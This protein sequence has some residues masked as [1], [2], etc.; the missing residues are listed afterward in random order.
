MDIKSRGTISAIINNVFENQNVLETINWIIETDDDIVSREDLA[1][2][3]FIGSLMNIS[4][5]TARDL[6]KWEI[7]EK[8]Y[9]KSLEEIYGKE[10]GLEKFFEYKMGTD[11][12]NDNGVNYTK[13]VLCE[14]D[15]EDIRNMLRPMIAPFREKIRQ[16]EVL[17]VI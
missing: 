15:I 4:N 12:S 6:K 14:E 10:E 11:E 9:K 3:Y 1:L 7:L 17:N 5:N 16:E 13:I 2:G 8:R